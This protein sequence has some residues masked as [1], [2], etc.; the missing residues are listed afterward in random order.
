MVNLWKANRPITTLPLIEEL[1]ALIERP[2]G[3]SEKVPITQ[4]KFNGLLSDIPPDGCTEDDLNTLFTIGEEGL[5]LNG[6]LSAALKPPPPGGTEYA[7][8]QF[9]DNNIRSIVELLNPSGTSIRNSNRYTETGSLRP[10]FGF[11]LDTACPF[12]GEEKG[13][14]NKAD[15]RA[16][17]VNKLQWVYSPAPYMLG[18]CSRCVISSSE[19][20][21]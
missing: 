14:E 8:V 3:D 6:I 5:G 12:G 4:L 21:S 7:F 17:L 9:W 20:F 10:N 11:L 2:L 1:C 15:P 18:K 13:S 19:P 16:E